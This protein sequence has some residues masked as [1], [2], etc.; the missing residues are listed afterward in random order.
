[1]GIRLG[2][3]PDDLP[4]T[5][6]YSH[7]VLRLPFHNYKKALGRGALLDAGCYTLHA[8]RCLTGDKPDF[9]SVC[10]GSEAG[11][12]VDTTGSALIVFTSGSHALPDWGFGHAYVNEIEI[13]G[14]RGRV[15]AERA[16]SK[17]PSIAPRLFYI[18]EDGTEEI[19]QSPPSNHFVNMFEYFSEPVSSKTHRESIWQDTKRQCDLMEAVLNNSRYVAVP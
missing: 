5:E 6:E 4:I 17:P 14:E 3:R 18:K 7:R 2:Y 16:L 10:L 1:M 8:A 13:W 12:E 15:R 11:Y 9:L 19:R